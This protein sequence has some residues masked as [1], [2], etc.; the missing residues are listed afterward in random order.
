MVVALRGVY[1]PPRIGEILSGLISFTCGLCI[2]ANFFGTV[3]EKVRHDQNFWLDDACLIKS[4]VS[5]PYY[6]LS[7]PN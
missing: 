7:P 3:S 2:T 1:E 6:H 4:P 5:C